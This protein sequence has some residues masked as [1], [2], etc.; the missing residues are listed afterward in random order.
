[1]SRTEYPL[2]TPVGTSTEV[3]TRVG[4]SGVLRH[5]YVYGQSNVFLDTIYTI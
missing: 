3:P 4:T 2:P 1:M 5:Y